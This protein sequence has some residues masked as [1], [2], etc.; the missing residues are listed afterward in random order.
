MTKIF[1]DKNKIITLSK[2]PSEK[3]INKFYKNIYY[4]KGVSK[5]Y[6]KKYN[7]FELKYLDNFNKIFNFFIKGKNKK[8]LDI[9]CGEGYTLKFF[10]KKKH[11]CYG[12]DYS[13]YAIK[14]KNIKTFQK[15]KFFKTNLE[16]DEIPSKIKFDI[17]IAKNL[18]EH[19]RD[20]YGVLKKISKRLKKNGL[21]IAT[22]P[23]DDS[24]IFNSYLKKKNIKFSK[25][26]F[27]FPKEHFRYFSKDT[28]L[29]SIIKTTKFK[30]I[31]ILSSFPI[32]MFILNE[33]TNYYKFKKFGPEANKIRILFMNLL[34]ENFGENTINILE[35]FCKIGIGREI[36]GVFKK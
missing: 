17:I 23:N 33:K 30:N 9:G 4:Q 28:F 34:L 29:R 14:S 27:I 22:V 21:F 10:L 24:L 11:E 13:D 20:Y 12:I 2:I 18:L 35:T 16:K 5:T 31:K 32:E 3:E 1:L 19:V 26:P 15:I 7:N 8:I 25:A 6:K 36:I